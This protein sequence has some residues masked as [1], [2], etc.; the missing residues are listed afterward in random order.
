MNT[1][2][3]LCLIGS[4]FIGCERAPKGASQSEEVS[5]IQRTQRTQAA[6]FLEAEIAKDSPTPVPSPTAVAKTL[7]V[8]PQHSPAVEQK[9]KTLAPALSE[10]EVRRVEILASAT[11]LAE[12]GL[13]TTESML[14][15][16]S[17]GSIWK[18]AL[19]YLEQAASYTGTRRRSHWRVIQ[20]SDW[21][22]LTK[23]INPVLER[24][25]PRNAKRRAPVEDLLKLAVEMVSRDD[26]Y[27]R[28]TGYAL[29]D[30]CLDALGDKLPERDKTTYLSTMIA[31]YDV[32]NKV[33]ERQFMLKTLGEH[34]TRVF[35]R[36]FLRVALED[37]EWHARREALV[38]LDDCLKRGDG[39]SVNEGAAQLIYDA[40]QDSRTRGPL[41]R[42]AGRA[43]LPIVTPWCTQHLSRGNLAQYCRDAL[44][45]VRTRGAFDALY[46][47][48]KVRKDEPASSAAAQYVF[49]DEFKH[50]IP[51]ADFHYAKERYYSLLF[52]VLGQDVREPHATGGI[53]RMMGSLKDP[54]RALYIVRSTRDFYTAKW[55]KIEKQRGH[56]FLFAELDKMEET[57]ASKMPPV[58][59]NK[60]QRR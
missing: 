1:L 35:D 9:P 19:P 18:K 26:G 36:F 32:A 52:N 17:P 43:Q 46:G 29:I 57:L 40:H 59:R 22:E 6:R 56:K 28:A 14:K 11:Q 20:T 7:P 8:Q 53:V 58:K 37:T 27:E 45:L 44:S 2:L 50:L 4:L 12:N 42:L 24:Y 39:C 21:M 34:A 31:R 38:A 55:E 16:Y 33:F 3:R 23:I 54:K 5:E 30:A 10:E 41:F 51:Y 48:L 13:L 60:T 49:R 15:G 25:S 47:W